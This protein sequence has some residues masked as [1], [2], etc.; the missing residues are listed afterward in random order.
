MPVLGREG[1]AGG[2]ILPWQRSTFMRSKQISARLG[3][4]NL[5]RDKIL[6]ENGVLSVFMSTYTELATHD[7]GAT[8]DGRHQRVVSEWVCDSPGLNE[9]EEISGVNV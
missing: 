4:E 1:G 5:P 8:H 3:N 2:N 7:F 9:C 6:W